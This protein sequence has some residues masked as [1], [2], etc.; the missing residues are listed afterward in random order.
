MLVLCNAIGTPLDSKYID[1][2]P[3]YVCMTRSHIVAASKEA[4]YT[5]QFKNIKKLASLEMSGK[6]KAGQERYDTDC[7]LHS[8][9]AFN[10]C[11]KGSKTA[12]LLNLRVGGQDKDR[13]L[14]IEYVWTI[15]TRLMKPV[16]VESD[17]Q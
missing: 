3:C 17:Q 1:I 16:I 5:W 7:N 14:N 8:L 6:R 13:P 2:E 4:F 11:D 15:I 9:V 10:H 12:A